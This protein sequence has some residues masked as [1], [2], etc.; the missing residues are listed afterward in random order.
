MIKI[1]LMTIIALLFLLPYYWMVVIS[2][3]PE[4]I[5]TGSNFHLIPQNFT[6]D[7][8]SYLFFKVKEF[9]RWIFNSLFTSIMAIILVCISASM[10]G[11]VLARKKF[12]GNRIIFLVFLA[13]MAIPTNI[14]L[15]P[16]FILMKSLNLMNT[17]PSMFLMIMASAGGV[18]LMKQIIQTIPNE[19][20]EAAMIDG[21]NEWQIFYH[22]ILPMI[23][24][25]VI[26]LG[27]FTFVTTYNDYFWQL[28]MVKDTSMKTLPLA[29]AIF[30][31]Y[32]RPKIQLTMAAAFIASWPLLILFFIF[33][34]NFI[35][36]ISIGGVKG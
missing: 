7:N 12:P 32:Q 23:K 35:K 26:S 15:L 28:L 30:A 10:A 22:I 20:L 36:G 21:M 11:Y 19:I 18:F 4:A 29:V 16:R 17:Y 14:L 6:L 33:Y 34:K 9:Y 31:D 25:G 1:I 5:G 27:I 2:F 8:Y 13:S 24:P 3:E